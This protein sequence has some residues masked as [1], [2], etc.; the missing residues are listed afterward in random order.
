[1]EYTA[2]LYELLSGS[3][4]LSLATADENGTPWASPVVYE[5]DE[6]QGNLFFIS[7]PDSR[8]IRNISKNNILYLAQDILCKVGYFF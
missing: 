6:T 3:T 2:I 5:F 7:A 4:Y 8:H 1:M